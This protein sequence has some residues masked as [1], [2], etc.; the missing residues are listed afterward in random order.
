MGCKEQVTHGVIYVC[1]TN[2]GC[3]TWLAVETC[4]EL[5]FLFWRGFFKSMVF[6]LHESQAISGFSTLADGK[7]R[8]YIVD[9][10]VDGL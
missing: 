5:S 9:Y 10:M 2:I 4:V 7:F 1:L 8:T 3:F 6:E